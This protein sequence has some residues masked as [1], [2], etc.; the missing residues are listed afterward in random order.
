ME[1]SA[2]NPV[3]HRFFPGSSTPIPDRRA[4]AATPQ[5]EPDEEAWD[6]HPQ[7][8]LVQGK[9]VEFFTVGALAQALG[10]SASTVREWERFGFIPVALYR[11][12][13][14]N[15]KKAKRLYTRPQIEG[16]V[17]IAREEGLLTYKPRNIR[18]TSFTVR[19]VDLF[20]RLLRE[21]R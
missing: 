6:A 18:A 12:K 17:E 19:V 2:D 1:D 10:K 3:L 14:V 11:T 8:F 5:P 4:P 21:Q 16:I 15:P 9:E 7:V 13:S 20:N